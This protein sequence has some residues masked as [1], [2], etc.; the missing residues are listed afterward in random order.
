MESEPTETPK[1]NPFYRKNSPQRRIEP[2]TL[3]QAGQ[4]AQHTANKLFRP[5]FHSLDFLAY[6]RQNK[7]NDV[8]DD[9]DDD[10]SNDILWIMICAYVTIVI[11]I[12]IF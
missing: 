5:L 1:E 10:N 4:R 7:Y 9:D 8:D 3:H 6:K 11:I 12:I 2:A